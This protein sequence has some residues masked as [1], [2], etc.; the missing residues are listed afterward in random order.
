MRRNWNETTLIE[1]TLARYYSAP[2][3][4]S[5]DRAGC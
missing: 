2:A 3:G 1:N 5:L 4:V